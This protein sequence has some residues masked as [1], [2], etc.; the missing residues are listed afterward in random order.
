MAGEA[1]PQLAELAATLGRLLG[2]A[3]GLV[4]AD[5]DALGQTAGLAL[6]TVELGKRLT[7]LRAQSISV[8]DATNANSALVLRG[9]QAWV[10]SAG[11]TVSTRD[12]AN[13]TLTLP[14]PGA[15]AF[16]AAMAPHREV[17][18]ILRDFLAS[19]LRGRRRG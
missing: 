2:R 16:D 14:H 8:R 13:A 10:S 5:L 4:P 9:N 7:A 19:E 1:H 17:N 12:R 18:V 11:P 3:R 15:A 6:D